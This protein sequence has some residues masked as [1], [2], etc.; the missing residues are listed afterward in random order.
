MINLKKSSLPF[1]TVMHN[2]DGP[3]TSPSGIINIAPGE[4]QA[5]ASFAS[6]PN[7]EALVFP[8]DYSSRTKPL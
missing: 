7:W 3:N 5:P 1:P 2:V 6:E 8:K 4:G